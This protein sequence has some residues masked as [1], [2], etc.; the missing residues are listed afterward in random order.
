MTQ[1]HSPSRVWRAAADAVSAELASHERR[2]AQGHPGRLLHAARRLREAAWVLGE[3][4]RRE[5]AHLAALEGEARVAALREDRACA[6]ASA[7]GEAAVAK[8]L[9][10][11]ARRA[12]ASRT[13]A[14]NAVAAASRAVG[15]CRALAEMVALRADALEAEGQA[16]LAARCSAMLGT[17]VR[18]DL[19]AIRQAGGV[20]WGPPALTAARP[21]PRG[22]W[23]PEVGSSSGATAASRVL[24]RRLLGQL[25][26][27]GEEGNPAPVQAGRVRDEAAMCAA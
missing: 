15:A 18:V 21:R 3:N 12:G 6:G 11:A 26:G 10:R 20:A 5:E 27:Q 22:E 13:R 16:A 14:E 7:T 8:N 24:A 17:T 23:G 1:D 2:E 19:E 4:A 25:L 9:R